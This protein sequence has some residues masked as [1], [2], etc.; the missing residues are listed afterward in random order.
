MEVEP[1]TLHE[2][3]SD[4]AESL[5]SKIDA[6]T[7]AN[8]QTWPTEEEMNH[9]GAST[10]GTT[11]G[12]PDAK[13]GTTP[14]RVKRVPRGTS[15]YQAAWIVDDEEGDDDEEDSDSEDVSM[16]GDGEAGSEA[17]AMSRVDEEEEDLVELTED[18]ESRKSR[19]EHEDLDMDEENDQ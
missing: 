16:K 11:N 2:P 1:T 9:D 8:E 12:L 13:L 19:A 14:K 17:G 3:T 4:D 15:S 6:D 7:M 18:M 5:T 10:S